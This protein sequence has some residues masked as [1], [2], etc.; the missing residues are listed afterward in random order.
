MRQN[1]KGVQAHKLT[2]RYRRTAYPLISGFSPARTSPWNL[3]IGEE[4][5]TN[6]M[7]LAILFH[8]LYAQHVSDINIAIIRSLRLCCWITTSVVFFSVRCVLQILCGWFWVVLVL[9]A[10]AQVVL[11]PA[12]RAT[13]NSYTLLTRGTFSSI[14]IIQP[15]TRSRWKFTIC[16]YTMILLCIV[17]LYIHFLWP[18]DGPQWSKHVVIIVNRVQDSCVLTYPT[19]SLIRCNTT[20]MMHRGRCLTCLEGVV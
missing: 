14:C 9:Q 20:G 4:W 18:E 15:T 7:S 11:Q 2:R 5:K 17:F 13:S 1:P 12:K 16:T 10:E 19:P 6:L 8:I 3:S